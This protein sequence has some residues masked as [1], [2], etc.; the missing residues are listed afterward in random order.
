MR[1]RAAPQWYHI[2]I[3]DGRRC[4]RRSRVTIAGIPTLRRSIVQASKVSM[5]GGRGV[6]G[7]GMRDG[8][9]LV[10]SRFLMLSRTLRT[11]S[12]NHL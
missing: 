6:V 10:K 7:P 9:S 12:L 11:Q 8:V 4:I 2:Y 3:Y 5:D 1:I